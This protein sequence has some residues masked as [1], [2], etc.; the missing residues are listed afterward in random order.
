MPRKAKMKDGAVHAD[1]TAKAGHNGFDPAAL[2]RLIDACEAEDAAIEAIMVRARE[3]A[4]PHADAIDDLKKEAAEAGIAKQV[5]SAALRFR[6][7]ERKKQAVREKLNGSQQDAYD[8]VLLALGH[9][10]DTPLGKA[11][12][13]GFEASAPAH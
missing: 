6:K 1:K 5:F 4:Q 9:L 7:L 8:S 13:G 3:D 11:A 12:M 10:A 2:E